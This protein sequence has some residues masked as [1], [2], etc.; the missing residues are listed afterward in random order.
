MSVLGCRIPVMIII[1]GVSRPILK[2]KSGVCPVLTR[3]LSAGAVRVMVKRHSGWFFGASLIYHGREL[4]LQALRI[5]NV[6]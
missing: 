6:E 2:E 5:F 1:L 3:G 4:L